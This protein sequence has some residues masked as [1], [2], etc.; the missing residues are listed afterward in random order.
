[1]ASFT[2]DIEGQILLETIKG[3]SE[4]IEGMVRWSVH[5]SDFRANA[6]DFN[7]RFLKILFADQDPKQRY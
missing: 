1:M 4:V 2:L 5:T 6:C 7:C 3:T